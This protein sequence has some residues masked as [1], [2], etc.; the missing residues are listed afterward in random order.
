MPIPQHPVKVEL[1]R[2]GLRQ[3]E[4]APRVGV[5]PGVLGQ[6]L[7]GRVSIW[8]AL[9]RR[10]AD[11][12]EMS[13]Q[14]LFN[15]QPGAELVWRTRASQELPPTVEDRAALGAVAMAL[16]DPTLKS[17]RRASR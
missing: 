5:T 2:R 3:T 14:E 9:R 10:I 6:V 12:L 16:D 11:E 17:A 8:P 13:E 7:N 15:S 1:S 4:F